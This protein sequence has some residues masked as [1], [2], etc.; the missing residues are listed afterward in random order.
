MLGFL[1]GILDRLFEGSS[2]GERLGNIDGLVEGFLDGRRL[3]KIDRD[4]LEQ[5]GNASDVASN[6]T[7]FEAQ[8]SRETI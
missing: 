5:L 4:S 6:S 7:V 2:D 3:G 8:V 1:D